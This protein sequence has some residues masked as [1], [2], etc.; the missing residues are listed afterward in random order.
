MIKPNP[1]QKTDIYPE[2]ARKSC[3]SLCCLPDLIAEFDDMDHEPVGIE[4]AYIIARYRKIEEELCTEGNRAIATKMI[5]EYLISVLWRTRGER[6]PEKAKM[7]P[8]KWPRMERER[9]VGSGKWARNG[10]LADG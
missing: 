9:Q 3:P 4:R 7:D 8:D 1:I 2:Q 5:N 6:N 10:R